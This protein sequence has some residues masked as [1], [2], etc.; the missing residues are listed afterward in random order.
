MG[1]P[2][3]RAA[4]LLSCLRSGFTGGSSRPRSPH[5]L[6]QV[7]LHTGLEVPTNLGRPKVP[8]N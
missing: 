6:F 1:I 7:T 4:Q 8:G 5:L 2:G 3:Q